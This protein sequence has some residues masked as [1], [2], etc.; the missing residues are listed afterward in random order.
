MNSFTYE[1]LKAKILVVLLHLIDHINI[2]FTI[3]LL[4]KI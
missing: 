4:L 1:F 2:Y 3:F